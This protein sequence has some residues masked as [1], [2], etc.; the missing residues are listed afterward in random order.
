MATWSGNV[1]FDNFN[2]LYLNI[3]E[4]TS[5]I[6]NECI[7]K[8]IFPK[9]LEFI[10]S[11]VY[12]YDATWTNGGK[13]DDECARTGQFKKAWFVGKIKS[14]FYDQLYIGLDGSKLKYKA[15]FV[16]RSISMYDEIENILPEIINN[17]L[18]KSCFNFPAIEARPFWTDFQN[19][20]E[21]NLADLFIARCKKHGIKMTVGGGS[22]LNIY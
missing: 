2:S 1:G 15:P 11:D 22:G 17:G 21:N 13:E 10:E 7:E 5:D 12:S 6:M 9:L 20:V 3:G 8:D 16:H 14:G 19:W 4:V 18:N